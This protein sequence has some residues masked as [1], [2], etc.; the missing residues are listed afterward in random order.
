MI[1]AIAAA[2]AKRIVTGFISSP[3]AHE[4]R[5]HAQGEYYL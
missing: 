4:E 1:I 2:A 3:G 5:M